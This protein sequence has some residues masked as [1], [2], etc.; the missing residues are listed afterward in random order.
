MRCL[1]P[2]KINAAIVPTNEVMIHGNITSAGLAAFS[3]A[4]YP[5]I[6]VGISVSPAACKHI[7]MIC[8]SLASSFLGLSSCKLCIALS[9]NGVAAESRPKKLA[10]KFKVMYDIDSWFLGNDGNILEKAGLNN[11]ANF[12]AAPESISNCIIPQKNAK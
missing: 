1:I 9:P 3:A 8:A 12:S 2:T 4:R 7:N 11:F 10:A 5:I 6:E